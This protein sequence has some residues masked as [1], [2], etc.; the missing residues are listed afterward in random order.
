MQLVDSPRR[1][2]H[3]TRRLLWRGGSMQN[4]RCG[5]DGDRPWTTAHRCGK[6]AALET[7]Q[8]GVVTVAQELTDATTTRRLIGEEVVDVVGRGAA[9]G[10]ARRGKERQ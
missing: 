1:H 2:P 7:D 4:A 9:L 3:G 5:T 6:V 10:P 8:G